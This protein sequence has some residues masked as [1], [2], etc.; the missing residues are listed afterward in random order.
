MQSDKFITTCIVGEDSFLKSVPER[1]VGQV[2]CQML[3]TKT[4]FCILVKS[5]ELCMLETV[6]IYCSVFYSNEALQETKKNFSDLIAWAHSTVEKPSELLIPDFAS[7]DSRMQIKNNTD[8][9]F[10]FN[11]C[12]KSRGPC[13]P[14]K[15]ILHGS[16]VHCSKIKTGVDGSSKQSSI[17]RSPTTKLDFEKKCVSNNLAKLFHNSHVAWKI[18]E[19]RD[20]IANSSQFSMKRF[21]NKFAHLESTGDFTFKCCQEIIILADQIATGA[22]TNSTANSEVDA[23][24]KN[25]L[26]SN[27]KK[28]KRHETG[29]FNTKDGIDIRTRTGSHHHISSSDDK[30]LRYC[31]YCYTTRTSNSKRTPRTLWRCEECNVPL[32]QSTKKDQTS[33]CFAMFHQSTILPIRHH[34][35]SKSAAKETSMIENLEDLSAESSDSLST[36]SIDSDSSSSRSSD[37]SIPTPSAFASASAKDQEHSDDSSIIPSLKQDLVHCE[38]FCGK[39]HKRGLFCIQCN[40]CNHWWNTTRSCIRARKS[41]DTEELDW[42]CPACSSLSEKQTD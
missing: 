34:A 24:R 40:S 41:D 16:Q 22:R 18:N 10:Y 30:K 4:N 6:V 38:C 21:K 12:V 17:I 5:S 19:M 42:I 33:N 9:W 13:E 35:P 2:I 20:I 11:E 36:S 7:K 23:K 15:S 14:L 8:Q 31:I 27:C 1:F 29:F 3:V 28:M 37:D 26:L 25:C 32:C 39:E